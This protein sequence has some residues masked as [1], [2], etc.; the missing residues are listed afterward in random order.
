MK[1]GEQS[2]NK[3]DSVKGRKKEKQEKESNESS[4]RSATQQVLQSSTTAPP[5]NSVPPLVSGQISNAATAN[6]AG[7]LAMSQ[8]PP[9]QD[10]AQQATNPNIDGTNSTDSFINLDPRLASTTTL[11]STHNHCSSIA[12]TTAHEEPFRTNSKLNKCVQGEIQEQAQVTNAHF[13]TVVEQ[14]RQLISTTTTATTVGNNPP[15]SRPPP[16]DLTIS[17]RG[18]V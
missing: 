9:P 1:K 5:S 14:M 15:T 12:I 18:A 8:V 7:M 13:A 17:R 16:G 2:K 10:A 6:N 3:H 11:A 4:S